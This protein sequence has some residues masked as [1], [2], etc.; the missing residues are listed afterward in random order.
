MTQTAE[1]KREYMRTWRAANQDK[2][3][4][5]RHAWYEEHKEHEHQTSLNW[6]RNNRDTVRAW[7][8]AWSESHKDY[9][10][11]QNLLRRDPIREKNY[12]RNYLYGLTEDGFVAMMSMQDGLCAICDKGLEAPHVDHDHATGQIR[13]LLCS[14]CNHLLGNAC[15]NTDTL[16]RAIQ[17]LADN[18]E[19]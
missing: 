8:K 15:D 18:Q 11:E 10:R 6:Q 14:K 12:R 1:E 19:N 4:A 5:S 9:I 7:G 17:Y 3:K 2:I 13:G 16:A